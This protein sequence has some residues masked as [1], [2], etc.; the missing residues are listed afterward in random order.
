MTRCPINSPVATGPTSRGLDFRSFDAT[1]WLETHSPPLVSETGCK[2]WLEGLNL[3]QLKMEFLER[4]LE[5]AL[6]WWNSQPDDASQQ[7]HR[8]CVAMGLE[9]QKL[10][11]STSDEILIRMMT[12]ALTFSL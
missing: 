5:R 1:I 10:S 11:R 9:P 8:V 12:V 4:Y 7:I 3:P 2:K 6:Q